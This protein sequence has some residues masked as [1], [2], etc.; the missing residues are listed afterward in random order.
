MLTNTEKEA[1]LRNPLIKSIEDYNERLVV[2]VK[3]LQCK[4]LRYGYDYYYDIPACR[5]IIKPKKPKIKILHAKQNYG[6]CTY[7]YRNQLKGHPHIFA[8]GSPCL[9][10]I[11]GAFYSYIR[12]KEY[13]VAI[14]LMVQFLQ[15]CYD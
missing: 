13:A 11:K 5:I 7:V 12:E 14:N 4:R 3:K 8:S 15:V 1:L 2:H 9:G 6:I 10:N